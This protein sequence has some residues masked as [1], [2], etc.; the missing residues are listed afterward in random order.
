MEKRFCLG[1]QGA[2]KKL[3]ACYREAYPDKLC[4]AHT[5]EEKKKT[6]EA[7]T[8]LSIDRDDTDIF[9]TGNES[10]SPIED[11]THMLRCSV[12][13][14]ERH[15]NQNAERNLTTYPRQAAAWRARR[16]TSETVGSQRRWYPH[17][18]PPST[19][20]GKG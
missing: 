7:L 4:P 20:G 1:Q 6:E 19:A 5:A 17:F 11:T 12:P 14:E 9:E 10:P 2:N 16:T 13:I 3:K 18:S 15:S 8:T